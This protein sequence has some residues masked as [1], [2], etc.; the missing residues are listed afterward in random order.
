MRL[1]ENTRPK[2]E[3]LPGGTGAHLRAME[4]I[5]SGTVFFDFSSLPVQSERHFK[6][7]QIGLD[8]HVTHPEFLSYLNHSCDPSVIVDASR[9]LCYTARDLRAGDELNSFYP[10]TE[11]VMSDPFPCRCGSSLCIGMIDG[12]S[13]L[14]IQVLRRYILNQHIVDLALLALSRVD[15]TYVE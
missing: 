3:I 7:I 1:I 9:K 6:T 10:A 12:A 11:W 14:P 15:D 13:K 2:I 5:A 4:P 8:T